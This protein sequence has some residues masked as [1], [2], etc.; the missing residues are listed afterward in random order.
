MLPLSI[1]GPSRWV[2]YSDV[3]SCIYGHCP[4]LYGAVK[5]LSV[6]EFSAKASKMMALNVIEIND[7]FLVGT[8]AY[9]TAAAGIYRLFIRDRR[10]ELPTRLKI[11]SLT[12]INFTRCLVVLQ[13][14]RRG[15]RTKSPRQSMKDEI[16]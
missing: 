15:S 16:L 10:I 4:H 14:W 8:V 11:N 13:P 3:R 6:G 7:L 1:D 12:F 9:I 2:H 5:L